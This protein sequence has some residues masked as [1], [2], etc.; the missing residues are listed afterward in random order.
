MNRIL[1]ALLLMAS[2]LVMGS[3]AKDE[4][5]E[6]LVDEPLQQY[7]DRFAEEAALRNVTIDYEALKISGDIRIIATPM[8]SDNVYT[9]TKN[10]IQS[11][12][13]NFIGKAQTTSNVS[14]LY[15]TNSVIARSIARTSMTRMRTEIA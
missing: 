4:G 11:S 1:T 14:F 15:S 12:W 8:S 2:M 6:F 3:C 9:P 10:P 7:F 13:I 5:P